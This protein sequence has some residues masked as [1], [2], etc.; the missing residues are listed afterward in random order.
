MKPTDRPNS[1]PSPLHPMDSCAHSKHCWPL[2]ALRLAFGLCSYSNA[3][4]APDFLEPLHTH[5][6]R[7]EL[8]K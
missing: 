7:N 6:V 4:R 5:A 8:P 3:L 1:I 2:L